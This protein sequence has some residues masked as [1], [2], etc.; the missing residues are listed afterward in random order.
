MSEAGDFDVLPCGCTL[1]L[2]IE[3]GVRTAKFAPCRNDC[4]NYRNVLN[5]AATQGKPVV[6]RP[7]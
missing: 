2:V 6:R 3:N 1:E 7:Q 4:I 5:E